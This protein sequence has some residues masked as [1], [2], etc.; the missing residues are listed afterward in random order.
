M[1]QNVSTNNSTYTKDEKAFFFSLDKMKKYDI[2]K[3]EYAMYYLRSLGPCF[4]QGCDLYLNDKFLTRS[5]N[6]ERHASYY[7]YDMP[8]DVELT[9]ES[10]FGV[11]EVEVYQ[12]FI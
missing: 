7:T 3:P 10:S 2:K 12:I 8:S 4:G 5:D 11:E 9:G 1:E 6:Y